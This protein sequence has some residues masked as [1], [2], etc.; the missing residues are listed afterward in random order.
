MT[1]SRAPVGPYFASSVGPNSATTGAPTV[2]LFGPMDET[3]YGPTGARDRV[4]RRRL[5][6][7][8]CEQALCRFHHEC[9]RFISVDEVCAAASALL[10]GERCSVRA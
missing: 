7:A 10:H 9:M 8:P 5:V 6:C 1:R 3:K 4:I 2:A